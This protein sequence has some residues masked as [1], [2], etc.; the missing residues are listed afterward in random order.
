ML[1]S[2]GLRKADSTDGEIFPPRPQLSGQPS[3]QPSGQL[4]GQGASGGA[5]TSHR[6]LP[7][8][9]RAGSVPRV[10]PMPPEADGS[11]CLSVDYTMFT[12]SSIM[13]NAGAAVPQDPIERSPQ[14]A[15]LSASYYIKGGRLIFYK[16]I[17]HH[18]ISPCFEDSFSTVY[19]F[20]Q[21]A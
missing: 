19:T 12:C 20:S 13:M 5:R 18:H 11:A 7:T 6:R 10:P 9:I 8:N 4:S 2:N 1:H 3:G 17:H 16:T 21:E 14:S 15:H